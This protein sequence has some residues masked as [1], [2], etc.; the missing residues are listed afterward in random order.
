MSHFEFVPIGAGSGLEPLDWLI[1]G[2]LEA[3]SLVVLY[4][5]SGST[6][7]FLALHMGLSIATGRPF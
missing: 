7:T 3:N 6:K 5:P 1:D 4:G 2:Y